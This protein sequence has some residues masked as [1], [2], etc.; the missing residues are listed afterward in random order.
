[1]HLQLK[2]KKLLALQFFNYP[3]E[4]AICNFISYAFLILGLIYK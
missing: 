1:M 2:H 4:L 3:V